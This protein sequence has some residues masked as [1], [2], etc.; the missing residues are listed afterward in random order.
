MMEINTSLPRARTFE[1]NPKIF[2]ILARGAGP[3]VAVH[4][5]ALSDHTGAA[6]LRVPRNQ[7][8][9]YSNQGASL[10]TVKVGAVWRALTWWPIT[11]RRCDAKITFSTGYSYRW[12]IEAVQ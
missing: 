10:S 12:P 8:G 5:V 2:Q 4:K 1:P 7:S 3:G 9:N 11:P 6:E